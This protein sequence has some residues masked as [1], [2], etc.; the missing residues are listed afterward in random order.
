MEHNIKPEEVDRWEVVSLIGLKMKLRRV[1]S[2]KEKFETI[3]DPE[4]IPDD[5][6]LTPAEKRAIIERQ[7]DK[8]LSHQIRMAAEK[9]AREKGQCTTRQLGSIR[10]SSRQKQP[11]II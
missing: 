5:N 11:R 3:V 9:A 10:R 4:E 2:T 6:I 8:Y 7:R 1:E